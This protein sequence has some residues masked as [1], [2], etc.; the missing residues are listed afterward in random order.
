LQIYQ[1]YIWWPFAFK[2]VPGWDWFYPSKGFIGKPAWCNQTVLTDRPGIS[3]RKL[4]ILCCFLHFRRSRKK[5]GS[6]RYWLEE[7]NRI[8]LISGPNPGIR[9]SSSWNSHSLHAYTVKSTV[10]TDLPPAFGPE[11]SSIRFASSSTISSGTTFSF[12]DLL[13]CKK[14]QR[15]NTFSPWKSLVCLSNVWLPNWFPNKAFA[16]K[17]IN[18]PRERFERKGLNISLLLSANEVSILTYFS[19]FPHTQTTISLFISTISPA[20]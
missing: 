20:Q 14:Q 2:T 9:S 6:T 4:F 11:I 10:K 15:M 7:A 13:K 8:L 12:F 18:L 5:G 17:K 19:S 16:R 3:W 1:T